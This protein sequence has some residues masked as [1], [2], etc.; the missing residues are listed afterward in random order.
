MRTTP[1]AHA[2][3]ARPAQLPTPSLPRTLPPF[4]VLLHNY[5]VN[6]MQHVVRT[7]QNVT[8][9]DQKRAVV[10]MM[11]AHTVGIAQVLVTHKELAELYCER[12]ASAR[13]TASMEPVG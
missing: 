9:L 3:P 10:V 11:A 13:L 12:F 2:E 1:P 6:D 4:R 7:I 8:P 5:N